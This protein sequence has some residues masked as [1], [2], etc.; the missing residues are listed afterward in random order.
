MV[1]ES[2]VAVLVCGDTRELRHP[3]MWVQDCAAATQNLLL[4][5]HAKELGAVWVGVYP[6]EDRMVPMKHLLA[7]PGGIEPF[8]LVPLGCPAQ[9]P[10]QPERFHEERIHLNRW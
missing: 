9:E 1:A 6:K 4:A 10:A 3:E 2:P 7:L 5:A 8:A